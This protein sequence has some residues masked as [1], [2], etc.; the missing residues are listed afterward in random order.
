MSVK[1]I[2]SQ[3]VSYKQA[4]RNKNKYSNLLILHEM[5]FWMNLAVVFVMQNTTYLAGFKICLHVQEL[6]NK[7]NEKKKEKN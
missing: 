5:A 4:R 6:K 1:I 2:A 7:E 3:K